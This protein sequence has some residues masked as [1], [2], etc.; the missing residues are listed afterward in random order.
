MIFEDAS[1][2]RWRRALVIFSFLALAALVSLALLVTGMLVSPAVPQPFEKRFLF[3]ATEVREK[4]KEYIRPVYTKA[5]IERMAKIRAQ[6]KRRRE[7][8]VRDAKAGAMPL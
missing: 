1:R 3:S 7:R 5:Q 2:R 4:I 6:E 8:L